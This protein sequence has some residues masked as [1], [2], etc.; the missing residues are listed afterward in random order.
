[1]AT[2]IVAELM[3]DSVT[4]ARIEVAIQE[5]DP[6]RGGYLTIGPIIVPRVRELLEA[7][8]ARHSGK[9]KVGN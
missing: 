8:A 6:D 9:V 3:S 4:M 5:K 2:E 7:V 1:M